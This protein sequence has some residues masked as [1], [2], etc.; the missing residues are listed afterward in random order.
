[1]TAD[2]LG[3]LSDERTANVWLKAPSSEPNI[4]S[5]RL[6]NFELPGGGVSDPISYDGR[7]WVFSHTQIDKD[8]SGSEERW[9]VHV[10]HG[11]VDHEPSP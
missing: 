10:D 3:L 8:H 5:H 2:S 7:R 9:L 11:P 1:L 4:R 6:Y